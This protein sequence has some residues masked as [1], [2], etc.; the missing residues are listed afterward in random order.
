MKEKFVILLVMVVIFA[1]ATV[2]IA[3]SRL[4]QS[5]ELAYRAD[6]VTH[7][8]DINCGNWFAD[9]EVKGGGRFPS[10]AGTGEK[11]R[12]GHWRGEIFDR[13][14]VFY[15]WFRDGESQEVVG[16]AVQ[17]PCGGS[18][19]P[20]AGYT[21]SINNQDG[22]WRRFHQDRVPQGKLGPFNSNT[23]WSGTHFPAF[24]FS[25]DGFE[26]CTE[27]TTHGCPSGRS[28]S[29]VDGA[30]LKVDAWVAYNPEYLN[31]IGNPAGHV[32]GGG[33]GW[34]W[35]SSDQVTLSSA[36][37][38]VNWQKA[39]YKLGETAVVEYEI[40]V[41]SYQKP[42][43]DGEPGE[44]VTAYFLSVINCN[45]HNAIQGFERIPLEDLTGSVTVPVTQDL[46]SNDLATCQNRLRAILYTS[47][48]R[49]DQADTA[50][51]APVDAILGIGPPPVVIDLT[52]DKKEAFEGD[53]IKISWNAKGNVTKYHITVHIGGLPIL[54]KDLGAG[55]KSITVV[56]PTTGIL[57]AELTAYDRCQPSAVKK[58]LLTIGNVYPGLCEVYP[59][60]PQCTKTNK[61]IDQ[62]IAALII[63]G[64]FL[65]FFVIW[66]ILTQVGGLPPFVNFLIAFC[67]VAV[68][69]IVLLSLG[70]FDPL[71]LSMARKTAGL[72]SLEVRA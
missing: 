36:L 49:I 20:N 15:A 50:I 19:A 6:T 30:I 68:A 2:T 29:I 63:V 43:V 60:L 28:E 40:P 25:I 11:D 69:F 67:A 71:L 57:E 10:P 59:E 3:S 22:Q 37:A 9:Y 41:V 48:V 47:L 33:G 52:F 34:I 54:D 21:F 55:E 44:T 1:T 72:I 66:W 56:A 8:Q 58:S 65:L 31:D 16:Q 5:S 51:Q 24:S 7:G 42:G 4:Q 53:N 45:T 62:I 70:Y 17:T 26:F 32:I 14:V 12:D 13:T 27:D 38:K 23:G 39:A 46:Y 64:L 18:V 61:L 35:L